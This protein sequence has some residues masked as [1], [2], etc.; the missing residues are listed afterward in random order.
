MAGNWKFDK[1]CPL[2]CVCVCVYI[3]LLQ[4]NK[5]SNE[6]WKLNPIGSVLCISDSIWNLFLVINIENRQTDAFENRMRFVCVYTVEM[7]P[8][9]LLRI[10][11]Q[12]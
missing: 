8:H 9:A 6:Q 12:T 4:L 5:M 1:C 2:F 3:L 10:G 11:C 7:K